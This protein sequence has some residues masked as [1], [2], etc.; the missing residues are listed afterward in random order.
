MW[1]FSEK[2]NI[3]HVYKVYNVLFFIHIDSETFRFYNVV[4]ETKAYPTMRQKI[5]RSVPRV[6]RFTAVWS[7]RYRCRLHNTVG[8]KGPAESPG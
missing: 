6:P 5:F 8:K 3:F 7:K 1:E 2:N 4:S